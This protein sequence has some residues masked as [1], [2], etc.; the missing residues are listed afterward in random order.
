MFL[1]KHERKILVANDIVRIRSKTTSHVQIMDLH[2]FPHNMYSC[3]IDIVKTC[4]DV[5][6]AMMVGRFPHK[7]S[8]ECKD[9]KFKMFAC[10][11][12]Q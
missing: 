5:N 11:F 7:E 12:L 10:L 1:H 2:I 8:M 9:V 6:I 3:N 4:K